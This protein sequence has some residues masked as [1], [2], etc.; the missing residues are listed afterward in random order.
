MS[1]DP[2]EERRLM[3]G[4]LFSLKEVVARFSPT[5][6]DNLHV[7]KTS[8]FILHH[9]QSLTGFVFVINTKADVPDL[10]AN[11]QHI[12]SNIFIEYVAKNPLY[13]FNGEDPIDNPLFATKVE[14]YLM[15]LPVPK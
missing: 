13:H 3:F 11:L 2:E 9:F 15:S 6:S 14:E 12:Y 1:D 8:N 4:M 10:Y 5:G 7:M